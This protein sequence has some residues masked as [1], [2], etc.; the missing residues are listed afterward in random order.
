M[1]GGK[2][3]GAIF[4]VAPQVRF[5]GNCA[6]CGLRRSSAGASEVWVKEGGLKG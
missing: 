4:Q 2:M 1:F 5:G 6:A 3:F